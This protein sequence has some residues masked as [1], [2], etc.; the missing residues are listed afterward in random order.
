MRAAR[1]SALLLALAACASGA[2]LSAQRREL[3]LVAGANLSGA[4]G[5]SVAS[6]K[7]RTGFQA[8]LSLRFPR[9]PTLSFQTELLVSQRR[10]FGEREENNLPPTLAGPRS[11]AANMLYAQIPLLLRLQKGYSTQ[12]P[13]RPFLALGPYV[14]IRLHCRRELT[15]ADGNVRHTDCSFTPSDQTGTVPFFPAAYQEVDFGLLGDLG[16]EVRRL[17]LRL[18]GE[19]SMRNLVEQGVV[20]TTPF[21]KAKL[22]SGSVS[23]E[24]LLRVL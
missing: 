13:V 14:A 10:F 23:V 17:T 11:D 4:S 15:E 5:G 16:L 12:R 18:R 7:S 19:K 22:W 21:E 3:T 1:R 9:G 8:G 20:P 2:T 6:S 24:Y